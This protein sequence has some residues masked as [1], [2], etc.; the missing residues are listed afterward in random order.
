MRTTP[1]RPSFRAFERSRMLA[2]AALSGACL[3]AHPAFADTARIDG[4]V[5]QAILDCTF[6]VLAQSP[7]STSDTRAFE[8]AP[9]VRVAGSAFC[10]GDGEL[11]TAAHVFEPVLGGRFEVPFVRDRAGRTYKVESVVRYSMRDDFVTFKVAG[12]PALPAR[13]HNTSNEI[14][15]AFY[16]AWRER[17]GEIAFGRTQYR[18]RTTIAAFGRDGWIEFGPA[19]GHGASGA[20]LFDGQ[21]QVVGLINN[22][23]SESADASGYAVPIRTIEDAS[24]QWGEVA[25]H[26]PMRILGMPSE[27][28]QPL[29]G[30]IPLPAPYARF[31][32]HMADVRR[33]Y[34]AHMLPYSLSL[35]GTDA[36]LRDTQRAGLCTALGPEY[37]VDESQAVATPARATRYERGC[38]TPWN[39]VGAALVR[40]TARDAVASSRMMDDARMQAATLSIGQRF[41]QAPPA[42]CTSEDGLDPATAIDSFTDHTGVQWQVRASAAQGCD[43][44]VI[45]MSRSLPTGTLTF[46]RGAPSAYV[47]AA[48]MQLKVLT[49]IRRDGDTSGDGEIKDAVLAEVGAARTQLTR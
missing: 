14:G 20:A 4:R 45:S 47:D 38:D 10:F 44:V 1:S 34:Y 17:D 13:P 28:N 3:L 16:L 24:T 41:T 35:G 33:T 2:L 48:V 5:K 21:G 23:S 42:P 6:E 25:L 43:W 46:V 31:E 12:L 9:L 26:D 18:G 37:C 11:A 39:A 32:K 15:D 40:C 36:P 29:I 30:G 22:R 49:S 8:P 7:P 27:R 19:P